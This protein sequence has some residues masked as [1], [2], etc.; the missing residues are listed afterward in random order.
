MQASH[1]PSRYRQKPQ[2]ARLRHVSISCESIKDARYLDVLRDTRWRSSISQKLMDLLE[3]IQEQS[4][5][6]ASGATSIQCW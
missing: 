3:S 5:G 4:I 1:D 2:W 6:R